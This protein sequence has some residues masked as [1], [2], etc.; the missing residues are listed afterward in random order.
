MARMASRFVPLTGASNFRDLGGLP[1]TG[2]AT[3]AWGQ[4]FR[5]DTLQELTEQD[6]KTVLDEVGIHEPLMAL[7]QT[8]DEG[9][10]WAGAI[11]AMIAAGLFEA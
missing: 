5:S 6:V 2:G 10:G 1:I 3:T 8:P 4:V 7:P 11:D 9:E